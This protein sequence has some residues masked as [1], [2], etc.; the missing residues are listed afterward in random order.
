MNDV[1]SEQNTQ[2]TNY[3]A[4]NRLPPQLTT[5]R[6]HIV[7]G[8]GDVEHDVKEGGTNGRH[9][10]YRYVKSVLTLYISK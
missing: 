9:D 3:D 4:N 8:A 10:R 2:E 7:F 5:S 1:D 6:R